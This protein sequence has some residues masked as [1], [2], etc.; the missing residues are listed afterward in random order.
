M[1][2]D[3]Y[4]S[5]GM[6]IGM[7]RQNKKMS[8]FV[9]KVREDGLAVLDLQTI[10]NRIKLA[11]KLLANYKNIMVVSRKP[12]AFNATNK[13][14]EIVGAKAINGRFLPGIITNP[15]FREYYEPDA[16]LVTDPSVDK[17]AIDEA[18]KMR[19]P[20]VSLVDTF[21]ETSGI[22][23]II[24]VNNKGRKAIAMTYFLLAREILK[25]RGKI[26]EDSEFTAKP[27]EFESQEKQER[28]ERPERRE[29]S[30]R[31]R[32]PQRR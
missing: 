8:K 29:R 10:D 3:E 21:N 23:F 15:S 22:D 25:V 18:V 27:E 11:A 9:Y 13:F 1:A 12:I 14:A 31:G 30:T 20:I 5:T 26:A 2:F 32:R 7:K 28:R 19:V 17:Q 4:L 16:L 24:P 6:H